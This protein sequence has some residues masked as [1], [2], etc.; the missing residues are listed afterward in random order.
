[1]DWLAAGF[2][3]ECNDAVIAAAGPAS[4]ISFVS[5]LLACFAFLQDPRPSFYPGRRIILLRENEQWMNPVVV[6]VFLLFF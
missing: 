2:L 5:A 4:K 1:M 6:A 3:C